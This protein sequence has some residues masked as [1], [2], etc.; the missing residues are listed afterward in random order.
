[1][2]VID[3]VIFSLQQHGGI[4]VYFQHL[5]R[6]LSKNIEEFSL[7]I[8]E[9]SLKNFETSESHVSFVYRAARLLE[10]YRH[11]RVPQNGTVFHSSYYRQPS[12]RDLPSVVTVHDFIYERFHRGPRQWVHTGQKNAAIRAAQAVI[13][14]SESTMQDLFEFVGE[15]PGQKIYVIHNGVSD[16]FKSQ[17]FEQPV[18]PFVLFVGQRGGYK[19]FNLLLAGISLLPDL[20]LL[21]V[22]GGP[23]LPQEL[24][25]VP[26]GV[27]RRVRHLGFVSDEELN[28]LYNRALCLVYPSSYE[29]F[30][31]PVVEAMKAGC[32]VVCFNCKAVIEVGGDA[33][34]IVYSDDPQEMANAILSTFSSIRSKL[35]QRGFFISKKYSWDNTHRQ[36]LDVYR[37]VKKK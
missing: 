28:V 31:I 23:I 2:L 4:S 5:L 25:N 36:T 22:G 17:T 12:Q 32:P 11:C 29:G 7:V 33:L 27:A 13:C 35:I 14:I 19:N 26:V 15:T 21:C 24:M 1:M 8:D 37:S 34:S 6:Y 20:E 18:S 10:R 9:P 30:G 3:G 16:I